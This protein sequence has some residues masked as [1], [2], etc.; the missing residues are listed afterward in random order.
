[1]AI[2]TLENYQNMLLGKGGNLSEVRKNQSDM[3]MNATFMNDVGYKKVYILSKEN[4]WEYVD[5]KYGKHASY[6]IL[7]DAVDSYLQFRPQVHYPVGTYVFI[8]DDTSPK[9]GFYE[10]QPEDPFKDLNFTVN[11]LWMIVGR[12][13]ATQF[14]R[15]NIIRCNWNFRWV[16]KL[17]G[18]YQIMHVWGSVRNANSYTSGVWTADYMT[19]L[20]QITSAW[21]PDTYQLY[22]DKLSE[23]D[24]CDSRY[25]QHD[26]RFM[27]T[28]NIIDPKIYRVTKV[29]D[30]VPLG[31][32]KMTLK[33]TEF[34]PRVDNPNLL[35]C[36]Y[37]DRM[38]EIKPIET[39]IVDDKQYV[40]IIYQGIINSNG[41]L[42]KGEEIS[43]IVPI[44]IGKTIYFITEFY[45]EDFIR[46][47]IESEYRIEVVDENNTLSNEDKEYLEK[48]VK[49]TVLDINTISIKV[50]KS[51]KVSGIQYKLSIQ[52][53]DGHYSSSVVLEVN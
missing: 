15:Y 44:D 43:N 33:Q 14:V 6:S 24:I 7:K 47:N 31:L 9:I 30:L 3:I 49:I 4:G 48:L 29:Q 1:M 39:E 38:G 25:I 34:D 35:L 51:I 36:N 19:Q 8:P 11:K 18:E 5:A 27:I 53:K 13:D 32:V 52:D 23:F 41:E 21:M 37:Y 20:D 17:H 12:D 28:N 26:E 2:I 22:G 16:Y 40:S 10:Y 50:G 46:E 42:E 45:D